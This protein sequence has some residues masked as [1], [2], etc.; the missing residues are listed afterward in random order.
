MTEAEDI[1]GAKG[2]RLKSGTVDV[3]QVIGKA[4]NVTG[5][6]FDDVG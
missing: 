5:A 2:K 1:V 6:E 4:K 3:K